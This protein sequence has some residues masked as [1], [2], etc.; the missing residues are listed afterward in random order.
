LGILT[1]G[2][3][4]ANGDVI[5]V[6]TN[7]PAPG[8]NG[9]VLSNLFIQAGHKLT[10]WSPNIFGDWVTNNN[11]FTVGALSGG[12]TADSGFNIPVKPQTGNLLGTTVTNISPYN[13]TVYNVWAGQDD[14][15][16]TAGYTNNLALGHL[17]LDVLTTNSNPALVFNGA[18]SNNA[19]YVDL[20]ELK[21]G[22]T[23]G[24]NTNNYNFPWLKINTNMFIYYARAVEN[25]GGTLFDVSQ[26]IDGQSQIGANGGRLRWVS[27]YAGYYSSTNFYFTNS[28]GM[29]FTNSANIALA[30]SSTID[31]DSDGL[32]N[33]MDPTPFFVPQQVNLMVIPTNVPPMSVRV[34]WTTIPNATNLICYAT[35][36]ASPVW[37]PF[38]N[39]QY[40]YYG[41]N[42][43]VPNP[44]LNNFKSPQVYIKNQSLP[45]N[46]QETNVWV[47]DVMTNMPHYYK[48]QVQPNENFVP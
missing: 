47:V 7:T 40:W 42:V 24:N 12:G 14:G 9:L 44:A 31:S 5:L 26:A 30:Q 10:L 4:T 2:S 13:K 19:M 22:A 39:F 41:N 11:F 34:Q 20:L 8:V 35:N 6:A 37:R 16:S 1:N 46:S 38:T 15:I 17:V 18:S 48:V 28:M 33:A 25:I 43:P 3:I 36:L 45:D 32:P 23:H 29:V 27:S 21:D